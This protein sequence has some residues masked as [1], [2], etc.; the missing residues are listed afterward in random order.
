M[1]A[2]IIKNCEWSEILSHLQTNRLACHSFINAGGRPKILYS[3]RVFLKNKGI[4][5][6][7]SD[8]PPPKKKQRKKLSARDQH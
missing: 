4:I 8:E 3:V 6:V 1:Q 2:V 5:K 7:F